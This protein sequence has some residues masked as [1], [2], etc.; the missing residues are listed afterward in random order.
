MYCLKLS[1]QILPLSLQ[2]TDSLSKEHIV[3]VL[4]SRPCYKLIATMATV[5]IKVPHHIIANRL[6]SIK[7]VTSWQRYGCFAINVTLQECTLL[8][9]MYCGGLRCV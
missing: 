6:H 5:Y 4:S 7:L 9:S 8:I 1:L 2:A 3:R